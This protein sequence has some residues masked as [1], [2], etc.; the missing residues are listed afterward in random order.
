MARDFDVAETGFDPAMGRQEVQFAATDAQVA[1][2]EGEGL[3]VEDPPIDK[4]KRKSAAMARTAWELGNT[5]ATN[6]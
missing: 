1:K 3:D 2:L 4:P 6:F 5:Y